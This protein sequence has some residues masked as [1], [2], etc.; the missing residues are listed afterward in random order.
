[1]A[2]LRFWW[3]TALVAL[4]LTACGPKRPAGD[5]VDPDGSGEE[6]PEDAAEGTD[7]GDG[8]GEGDAS[9]GEGEGEGES[10]GGEPPT[11]PDDPLSTDG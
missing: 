1:M 10:D 9:E 3:T 11:D 7:G 2:V 6:P 5:P 8:E 4:L